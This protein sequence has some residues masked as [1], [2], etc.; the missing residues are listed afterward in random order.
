MMHIN[1]ELNENDLKKLVLD[2]I[3]RKTGNDEITEKDIKILVKSKQNYKFEWENA[4]FKAVL[5][6]FY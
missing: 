1:V 6:K 2:E 4:D 5:Y 3:I